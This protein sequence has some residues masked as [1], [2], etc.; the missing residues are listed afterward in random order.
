MNRREFLQ[1]SAILLAAGGLPLKLWAADERFRLRAAPGTSNLVGAEYGDTGV[2]SYNG[3]IPGPVLRY[4][5]GDTL[6]VMVENALPQPTTV[7]WHGIRLPHAMDGVPHLTQPPIEPGETFTYRFPLP[8]AGTYWYH[9]HAASSEQLGRG[10]S[11][12]LIV[13]EPEPYPVD[14]EL[15][16]LLDDWRLN[17]DASIRDDF[18]HRHDESHAGRIG[19]TVTINGRLPRDVELHP[20]ERLRLRLVNGAN[21]RVFQLDFGE[22]APWVIATDGHPVEPWQPDN[23][24]I[25][26]GPSMRADLLLDVPPDTRQAFTLVDDFYPQR[27]YELVT[28]TFT[29]GPQRSVSNGAIPRLPANPLPEPDLEHAT[30]HEILLTGGAM[31][32][33]HE[34]Y[35]DGKLLSMRE[36]VQAGRFW[37]LNGIAAHGHHMEPLLTLELDASYRIRLVND[38]AWPHPMHLHGHAFRV[39]RRNGEPL[40]HEEWRDSVLLNARETAEIALVADNPGDWMFHCHVLEHQESGMM[41][42]VRVA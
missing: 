33:M 14:R 23:G 38:T 1:G 28:L 20:G 19:N 36:L 41:G 7:H 2:W 8:D 12:V 35:L 17:P 34:A 5:Q 4:R 40:G 11:G 16:W 31:G 22:L 26:L 27:A 6:E 29:G 24:L 30:E 3:Q 32:G 10:L 13:E 25:V 39:L 21:A 15:I 42:I 18:G 37:A 9:P